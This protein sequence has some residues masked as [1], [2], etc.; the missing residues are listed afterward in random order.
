MSYR[1]HTLAVNN[2]PI[3]NKIDLLS[4]VLFLL[5]FTFL[6]DIYTFTY[7]RIYTRV[8]INM[9]PFMHMY[10]S[11]EKQSKYGVMKIAPKLAY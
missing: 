1:G 3:L 11:H 7:T 6:T 10:I 8:H 5:H 9:H 2:T 4:G